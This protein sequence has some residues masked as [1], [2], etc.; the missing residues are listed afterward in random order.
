[1]IRSIAELTLQ[2]TLSNVLL[3][4]SKSLDALQLATINS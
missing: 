3:A 4:G 2:E 1:M